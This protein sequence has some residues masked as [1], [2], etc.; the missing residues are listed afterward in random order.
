M[1]GALRSSYNGEYLDEAHGQV[2]AR[3]GAVAARGLVQRPPALATSLYEIRTEFR[4]SGV[5]WGKVGLLVT[6][7][8]ICVLMCNITCP[9]STA[10]LARP[11]TKVADTA[12]PAVL[13]THAHG[14]K[15]NKHIYTVNI[16]LPKSLQLTRSLGR[17]RR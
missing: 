12:K 10:R 6:F 1:T 11:I 7:I 9:M 15:V 5:E 2:Q 14:Y 13:H 8:F 3:V 4:W 16:Q 17:G